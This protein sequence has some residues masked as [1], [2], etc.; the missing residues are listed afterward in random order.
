VNV[1]DVA[2]NIKK[3]SALSHYLFLFNDK[4][5][6]KILQFGLHF[7]NVLL[8]VKIILLSLSTDLTL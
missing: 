1:I 3:I 5:F 8:N 7:N 6:L 2:Q 4:L